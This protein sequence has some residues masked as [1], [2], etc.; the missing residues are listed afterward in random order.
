MIQHPYS[1]ALIV[2]LA[3]SIVSWLASQI[4]N[5]V[6]VVANRWSPRTPKILEGAR[7]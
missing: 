2:I 5:D 6:S 4:K 3:V 1:I 7:L